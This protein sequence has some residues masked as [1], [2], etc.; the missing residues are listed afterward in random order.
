MEK[1][2]ASI[3]R[4]VVGRKGD[5]SVIG[6]A[7]NFRRAASEI[8]IR[9]SLSEFLI[10]YTLCDQSWRLGRLH[11]SWLVRD[12]GSCPPMKVSGTDPLDAPVESMTLEGL[13]GQ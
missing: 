6:H 9:E 3:S 13:A 10:G 7:G 1:K 12:P 11:S 4:K 5:N 2:L 8:P